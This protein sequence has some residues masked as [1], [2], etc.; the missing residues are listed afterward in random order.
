MVVSAVIA[1]GFALVAS[2]YDVGSAK[3]DVWWILAL[4]AGTV[5]LLA[6]YALAVHWARRR[7]RLWG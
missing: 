1:V 4:V 7:K 5:A 2:Q 3:A 6:W